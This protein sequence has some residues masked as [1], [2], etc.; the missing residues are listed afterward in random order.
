MSAI[1]TLSQFYYGQT[2]SPTN[3]YIDF[4]ESGAILT[5]ILPIGGLTLTQY[6][7]AVATA[8]TAYGTQT[9][10]VSADRTTRKLTIS[11]SS[12]FKLL[13]S[14]GPNVGQSAFGLMGFSGSDVTG[15]NTYTGAA[16]CGSVYK[17]QIPFNKYISLL[18]YNLIETPS[19]NVSAVRC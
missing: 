14:S 16:G 2:T 13:I 8:L 12:N 10:T 1:Q 18:D 4:Q 7:A 5:A 3:K 15:A 11:A 17:N 9:Y 19:V 6:A